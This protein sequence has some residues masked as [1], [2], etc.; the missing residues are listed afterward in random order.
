[1][2][3]VGIVA[4]AVALLLCPGVR[5]AA[6]AAGSAAGSAA[7][8]ASGCSVSNIGYLS[9]LSADY[10]KLT[11]VKVFVRG[12]GS[13]V[14]L[15]DLAAGTTDFAAACRGR[16]AG[17]PADLEFIQVAWD[18]LVFIV[19]PTNPVQTLS[20]AQ[21][22]QVLDGVLQDWGRL[23]GP[24]GPI[25]VFLQRPTTGLSG[26]ESSVRAQVLDGRAPSPAPGT[27][28][29]ASTGIVEQFIEK[30]PAGFGVSGFSSSRKRS[31]KMLALDGVKPSKQTIVDRSYPLRRPLY[32]IVKRPGR[33]ETRAFVDFVLSARGQELI[34]GY[35]AISLRDMR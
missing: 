31:V 23:G 17:D 6:R 35:G 24:A 10:E 5:P 2:R 19:H 14:G 27:V 30:A 28:E 32:L 8:T 34:G 33:P 12:G 22:A 9:Q 15:D 7:L 21:A 25:K 26:V 11:G 3:H 13:V 4:A 29:L 16:N 20:F 18:A 1:M